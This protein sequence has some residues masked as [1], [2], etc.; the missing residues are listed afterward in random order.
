MQRY[1]RWSAF[2]I[3]L[4]STEVLFPGFIIFNRLQLL[5][6]FGYDITARCFLKASPF[7][8]TTASSFRSASSRSKA[9]VSRKPSF[10]SWVAAIQVGSLKMERVASKRRFRKWVA[11]SSKSLLITGAPYTG[12]TIFA[13]QVCLFH[14]YCCV[15]HR[16]LQERLVY[17]SLVHCKHNAL[18]PQHP[19]D[20]I[21]STV[22]SKSNFTGF[23][24][25]ITSFAQIFFFCWMRQ[26]LL[27]NWKHQQRG[28][29]NVHHYR[30]ITQLITVS[31]DCIA[32]CFR[33][34]LLVFFSWG[35]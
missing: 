31:D 9:Q 30:T 15:C 23:C 8:S 29:T 33:R 11:N 14:S 24:N 19:L 34:V 5:Y 17:A 22:P 27:L 16:G 26:I 25:S 20:K 3:R 12:K 13:K 1:W 21:H 35:C 18:I 10:S 4:S 7:Y 32:P 2:T 28:L 6:D